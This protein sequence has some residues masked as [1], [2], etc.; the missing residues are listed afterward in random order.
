M[1]IA[2][3]DHHFALIM[4]GGAGKRFWPLSRRSRPKQV[5]SLLGEQPLL[6]ET[7]DR[8]RPL[9]A[10]ERTVVVAT[11]AQRAAV[12]RCLPAGSGYPLVLEPVGRNTA[13]T[14]ALGAA[15]IAARDPDGIMVVLPADHYIGDV[16]AFR[17]VMALALGSTADTR[18]N[19][20]GIQPTY[21]ET[22]YGYLLVEEADLQQPSKAIRF[23]EKPPLAQA[24]A[25]I[26]TGKA[27]W[28]S[29]IFVWRAATIIEELRRFQPEL[30]DLIPA[31]LTSAGLPTPDQ[32]RR[33]YERLPTVSI[34]VAVLE[35][36]EHLFLVP[37]RFDW[38]DLGSWRG[39]ADLSIRHGR[40]SMA[41]DLLLVDSSNIFAVAPEKL[42]AA[43]G[44]A[45][46]IIVDSKD[47]LLICHRDQAQRVQEVV[48]RLE[49]EGKSEI[50]D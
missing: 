42:I 12:E 10:P 7:I 50:I 24:R 34:D 28:N 37:G 36:T 48:A 49:A 25:L 40:R 22:G 5:L 14:V 27:W 4:A 46:L 23:V 43:V 26:A 15:I 33:V 11:E 32:L 17:E 13:A 45:D 18:L 35:K 30:I 41:K 21:A 31:H 8:V 44:V 16:T 1:V 47:A 2:G 20:I 19:A 9:I 3:S 6:L 38:S 29:G 39:L